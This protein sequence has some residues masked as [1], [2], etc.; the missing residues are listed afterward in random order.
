LSLSS[1]SLPCLPYLPVSFTLRS[2][3]FR[4]VSRFKSL[5]LGLTG[6]TRGA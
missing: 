4:F 1:C 6:T 2:G 3:V 5:K